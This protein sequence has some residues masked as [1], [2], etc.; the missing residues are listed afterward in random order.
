MSVGVAASAWE[1]RKLGELADS[2]S[3]GLNASATAYDGKN[4]YLR[5]T[6]IDDSTRQF[7]KNDLTSPD[8]D[9][10][11]CGDYRLSE[12]D[13]VFART[14]ASVGKTYIYQAKDGIAYFAG[15]LIRMR[16]KPDIDPCFVFQSTLGETYKRYVSITSQRSGQPGVNAEE[17]AECPVL[18]PLLT[19]QQAIGRFFSRLDSLITLHQ[20]KQYLPFVR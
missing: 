16:L 7:S 14:G 1:Q 13:I 4:G 6:D 11:R 9:L 19:E 12:G 8:A 17:Y 10:S 3:Y 20:R 2:F 5:I 18:M 15:F